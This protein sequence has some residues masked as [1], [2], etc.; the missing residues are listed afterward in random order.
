MSLFFENDLFANTDRDYTNGVKISLV[1]PDLNKW[2]DYINNE[3]ANKFNRRFVQML[4]P[5]VDYKNQIFDF[6]KMPNS[7][8]ENEAFNI[9]FILGQQMY[10]PSDIS[11]SEIIKTDRPYAGWLYGGLGFHR[12][13]ERFLDIFEV[14]LGIVGPQAFAKET[15]DIVHDMRGIAKANGWQHQLDNEP[16]ISLN[17]ERKYRLWETPSSSKLGMDV[18]ANY[19]A[20]IGNVFTYANVGAEVRAGW[21]IPK[22]YG[23][24]QLGRSGNSNSPGFGDNA[25]WKSRQ[26][27]LYVFGGVNGRY[28]LR[29]IFL[30]GNT[31]SDSHSVR[32]EDFV[33]DLAGGVSLLLAG[34]YK[35]SYAQVVRTREYEGQN[36]GQN[37]GSISVSC[38]Y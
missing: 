32:K 24:N 38:L 36:D 15:Q 1:S 18:L 4:S 14:H 23:E 16:G 22:D 8:K 26:Y 35:L 10:T 33:G 28:V 6:F 12:K 13:S 31:F 37:F 20:N 34:K 19:G 7:H 2:E 5:L 29:N 21:N 25:R 27:S 11:R 17:A 30:D 3:H 9:E